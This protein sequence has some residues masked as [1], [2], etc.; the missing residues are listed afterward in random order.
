MLF[1]ANELIAMGEARGEARGEAKGEARGE[2][3]AKAEIT[4]VIRLFMQ[5]KSPELI[6]KELGISLAII[7]S[8]LKESGLIEQAQ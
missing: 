5:K 8:I 1:F 2:A 7:N 4:K 3:K 6:S